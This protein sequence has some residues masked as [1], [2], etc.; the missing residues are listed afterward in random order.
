M[1]ARKRMLTNIPSG[2]DEIIATFGSLNG[3]FEAKH[4]TLF[5]LPYTL[6]YEG[7]PVKRARC[8]RLAVENFIQAFK[9][10][11]TEGLANQF[12]EFNG[13]Y[14]PRSIRG[15]SAHAS[16]HSWGIA[17]D[18]CASQYPL[19][20]Q[21]RMPDAIVKAFQ[22]AGFFYGGDFKSRKDPMHFQ[23]ATHY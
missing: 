11:Q 1:A 13:I 5:D 3:G 18:M 19:G 23:L 14:A 15:Q 16:C 17:I 7:A 10:V 6:K 4:I 12:S 9:S 21:L 20:S 8:H 22:S 2:L